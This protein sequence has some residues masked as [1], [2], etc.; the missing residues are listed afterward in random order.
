MKKAMFLFLFACGMLVPYEP[1]YNGFMNVYWGLSPQEVNDRLAAT[2]FIKTKGEVERVE[3]YQSTYPDPDL[4]WFHPHL[5]RWMHLGFTARMDKLIKSDFTMRHLTQIES[6]DFSRITFAKD[7]LTTPNS[8]VYRFYFY[9]DRLFA[10]TLRFES[11]K[12]VNM[13]YERNPDKKSIHP[14][15]P[16][17]YFVFKENREQMFKKYGGFTTTFIKS[18][19]QFCAQYYGYYYRDQVNTMMTSYYQ[20]YY[21]N[22]VNY[23]VSYI[24]NHTL[25]SL[26]GKLQDRYYEGTAEKSDI[27][28]F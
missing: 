1:V 26:F 25:G 11:E 16:M 27:L 23:T 6:A 28:T 13:F 4:V 10:V 2:N 5:Y 20:K 15:Y 8:W 24:D 3:I 7:A 18:F 21:D 9:K 14:G 19:D 12:M 22:Y 17:P